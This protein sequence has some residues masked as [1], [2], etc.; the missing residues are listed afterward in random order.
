MKQKQVAIVIDELHINDVELLK[1]TATSFISL[2]T[3][4]NNSCQ[5]KSL[6]FIVSTILEPKEIVINKAKA[7]DYFEY[8]SC[9]DWKNDFEFFSD[10]LNIALALHI[11]DDSK[12]HIIQSIDMSPRLL[13][14]VFRKILI[15]PN[16]TKEDIMKITKKTLQESF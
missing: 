14:N 13:K 1:K 9:D 8:I 10:K 4:Y 2:V 3:H 6:K 16:K 7:S 11:E 15:S 5:E 12:S